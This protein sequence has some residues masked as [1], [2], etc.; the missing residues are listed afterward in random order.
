MKTQKIRTKLMSLLLAAIMVLSLL[1]VSAL[2]DK[3]DN[4]YTPGTYT[5]TAQGRNGDVKVTVTLAKN[6]SGNVSISDISAEQNESPE[7]WADVKPVLEQIKTKNGTDGIDAVSGATLSFNA[8]INAAND[9]LKKASPSMSGSGT[10]SDPYVVS[11]AAQLAAF[12]TAV[13]GGNTY[14]GKYV[15]LSADI[16]LSGIDNW[17]PIGQ[18]GKDSTA[19]FQGSFDGKGHSITGLKINAE[20]SSEGNYGLFSILGNQAVIKN[21]NVTGA[22]MTVTNKDVARVGVIAGDTQKTAGSGDTGLAAISIAA[23]QA[24]R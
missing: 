22:D 3:V 17:N 8:V 6:E 10:E 14:E 1:P 5:G 4:S 19:I 13:D 9:A 24:A 16:D 11:N 12:A 21:L 7:Y 15:V 20:I 18:E 2:A 23:Q